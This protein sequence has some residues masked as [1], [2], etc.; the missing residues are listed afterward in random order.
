M[1]RRAKKFIVAALLLSVGLLSGC[2]PL[3]FV[4][5]GTSEEVALPEVVDVIPDTLTGDTRADQS[6]RVNLYYISSDLQ[7]LVT[8]A[9]V[10]RVS[11]G[12]ESLAEKVM[13]RLLEPSGSADGLA[14]APEGTRLLSL[15]VAQGIATVNLSIEANES[16]N[17][18]R[19]VWMR[20][21]I[22]NTLTELGGIDAVNVLVGGMEES[23][24]DMPVGTLKKTDGNLSGLY[25][26][27]LAD[28]E[29]YQNAQTHDAAH[30]LE[31]EVT[32]YFAARLGDKLLPEARTVRFE[33]EDYIG[34]LLTELMKG[35]VSTAHARSVLPV[36]TVQSGL[37]QRVPEIVT[38]EDGLRLI[39]LDF[40]ANLLEEIDRMQIAPDQLYGALTLTLCRF[41]PEINGI[42][43]N[44]NGQQVNLLGN[45][46]EDGY[47]TPASFVSAVGSLGR[48]YFS[49]EESRLL[50]VD[51]VMAPQRT[52]NPRA[53][54]EE[55]IAGPLGSD[56]NAY[57]VVPD[58]ITG[59]DILG[60]RVEGDLVMIN[61]SS[62]F[63]RCCQS[64]SSL[65]ERNLIYSIVNTM[66]E[67]SGVRRVRFYVD[68]DGVD[69]L[70]KDV[71]LRSP[72]I[73]NPGLMADESLPYLE[74]LAG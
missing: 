26:R 53:L 66:T 40:D 69:T 35:P 19:Q 49:T 15:E 33:T 47:M 45:G 20:A 54:L 11:G 37:L 56:A 29:R 21:A 24:L 16:E 72:L 14:I 51:R 61:L 36:G 4:S 41:V 52:A 10:V 39:V 70:V 18:Q 50:A 60:V 43:I 22:T 62:N 55:L 30:A 59:A 25:A 46:Q 63:Y 65:Q 68:D 74:G 8:I 34:T 3:S 32:L 1:S 73:R 23:V 57:R 42:A 9:R 7:Q 17:E 64:L 27:Y 38:T 28:S 31:R 6:Y 67:L 48:L 5:S 12:D 13:E 58:G 44:L 2:M 71:F